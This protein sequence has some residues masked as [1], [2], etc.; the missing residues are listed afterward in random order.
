MTFER[1]VDELHS[2][3]DPLAHCARTTCLQFLCNSTRFTGF[4]VWERGTPN[5][6]TGSKE[7]FYQFCERVQT[8]LG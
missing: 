4:D 5:S 6:R 3:C 1:A 2:Q 7:N 8:S